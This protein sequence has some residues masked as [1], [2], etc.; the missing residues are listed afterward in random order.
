MP[1]LP[2][3]YKELLLIK[4]FITDK[5]K[6]NYWVLFSF[7]VFLLFKTCRNLGGL[8][9]RKKEREKEQKGRAAKRLQRFCGYV[10]NFLGSK[11]Q[12]AVEWT[13]SMLYMI[14]LGIKKDK[15]IPINNI[16]DITKEM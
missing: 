2:F 10:N 14:R 5:Y 6:E 16:T 13:A 8:G 15:I 1:A 11:G 12:E 4:D 7:F 3:G 9:Q